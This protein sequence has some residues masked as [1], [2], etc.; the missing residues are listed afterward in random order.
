MKKYIT[1]VALISLIISACS[2]SKDI[3]TPKLETP[4]AFRNA[5]VKTTGDSTSIANIQWK[6]FFTDPVLQTLIDSAIA[7]KEY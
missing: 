4:A 6:Q 5:D 3:D 2:V 7:H 1:G